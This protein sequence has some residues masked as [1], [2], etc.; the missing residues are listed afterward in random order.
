[1]SRFFH[2]KT[3]HEIIREQKLNIGK[4][5]REIQREIKRLER[6]ETR[7]TNEIK[8]LAKLGRQNAVKAMAKDLVTTKHQIDKLETVV[9]QLNSTKNKLTEMNSVVAV[10]EAMNGI[11]VAMQRVNDATQLPAMQKVMN[12]FEKQNQELGIK[13][14][15]AS[16]MIN[17]GMQEEGVEEEAEL[18]ID[19]VLTEIGLDVENG[20]K[21]VPQRTAASKRQT[22]R[23]QMQMEGGGMKG[24][25]QNVEDDDL[26]LPGAR[27]P[28]AFDDEEEDEEDDDIVSRLANL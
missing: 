21:P 20:L 12:D 13:T 23:R 3:P 25:K 11:C 19:R 18:E 9:A 8:K 6:E 26:D 28:K 27:K 15:M 5:I 7:M 1:M 17:S 16:D 4:S 22:E 2:K 24:R 10:T 14:T